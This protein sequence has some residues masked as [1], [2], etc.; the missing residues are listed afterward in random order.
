M[1]TGLNFVLIHVG[2]I[3]RARAFYTEKL[4]L[5]VE[6]EAPGF[7]QFA[8]PDDQG[9]ALA[10]VQRPVETPELWWDVEDADAAHASLVGNGVEI[11]SALEDKPFGRTFA[12]KDSEGNTMSFVKPR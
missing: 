4:G 9:A 7:V 11:S 12:I 8:R 3:E 10:I 1:V 2:D 5:T 6:A